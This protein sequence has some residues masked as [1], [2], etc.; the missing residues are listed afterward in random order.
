M[1]KNRWRYAPW[2]LSYF[3]IN[4]FSDRLPAV[5]PTELGNNVKMIYGNGMHIRL[6]ATMPGLNLEYHSPPSFRISALY[7]SAE[8]AGI[9]SRRPLQRAFTGTYGSK[10][11]KFLGKKS[12]ISLLCKTRFTPSFMK[13]RYVRIHPDRRRPTQPTVSQSKGTQPHN[14]RDTHRAKWPPGD[15]LVVLIFFF[16]YV[17]LFFY[18]L[19]NQHYFII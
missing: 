2:H 19:F 6:L 13:C 10:S 15:R 18:C 17:D 8:D 12:F 14:R 5:C 11:S 7:F 3:L 9:S 1:P 16:K 4:Q